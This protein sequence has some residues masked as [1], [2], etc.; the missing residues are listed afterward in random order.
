MDFSFAPSNSFRDLYRTK[1][2]H[3]ELSEN[4]VLRVAVGEIQLDV[5]RRHKG[6]S[7][8][9][10]CGSAWNTFLA[11]VQEHVVWTDDHAFTCTAQEI[12]WKIGYRRFFSLTATKGSSDS[13]PT[14]THSSTKLYVWAH[15]LQAAVG[16]C[17]ILQQLMATCSADLYS[18]HWMSMAGNL[19][20]FPV[21]AGV[22]AAY[23]E[24]QEHSSLL[25]TMDSFTLSTE[26][27]SVL[28]TLETSSA[29]VI[30]LS[31]CRFRSDTAARCLAE[32]LRNLN[33]GP[34][35]RWTQC[36]VDF[37]HLINALV[38][39]SRLIS[40]KLS[41][42]SCAFFGPPECLSDTELAIIFKALGKNQGLLELDLSS[43][44]VS[45]ALWVI[46]SQSLTKHTTLQVLNLTATQHWKASCGHPFATTESK[47][48]R[49]AGL[50]AVNTILQS[51]TD[52]HTVHLSSL[53]V[54]D[55]EFFHCAIRPRLRFNKCRRRLHL[56]QRAHISIRQQVLGRALG[57]FADDPN[58]VWLFVSNNADALCLIP[59]FL[60]S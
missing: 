9:T 33:T 11:H 29:I 38:G 7:R 21:S 47:G 52:L 51:N 22:L 30:E 45:D 15:C 13:A 46:L 44:P 32:S 59:G 53:S 27:C 34:K 50:Q 6:N 42:E 28:A 56:V 58:L 48:L 24:H 1:H 37:R 41:R 25:F 31:K 14:S 35:F 10:H 12:G 16:T 2:P 3:T 4:D 55:R 18:V 5:E 26:L 40:L 60:I 43:Q 8:G 57:T 39:D 49:P 54:L 20:D 36:D 17:D 23:L 19:V